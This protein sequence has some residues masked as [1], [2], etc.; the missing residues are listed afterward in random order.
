MTRPTTKKHPAGFRYIEQLQGER[1]W[2]AVLDAGTGASSMRWI[3]SLTTQRWTAVTGSQVHAGRVRQMLKTPL[4]AKDRLIVGNWADPQFCKGEAY[5]TVL[6]DYLLGALEGFSPYFQPYLFK[7]L[8][9]L[10]RKTL[11]V[12]GLEPYVPS[13]KPHTKA[14]QVLWEIGRFRDACVLMAGGLPYREYPLAWVADHLQS[15][16]F[17]VQNTKHFKIGYK[18]Q[19]VNAQIDIA[20]N[21]LKA[22]ADRDLAHSLG[23]RGEAL[24]TQALD[25]IKAE[26]ALR[27]CQNYVIAATPA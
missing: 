8:Y 24:R 12:K 9:P 17:V 3:Q 20:T 16:G 22:M 15:A 21:G 5:D 25:L 26:G 6:A 2:G 18:E 19:F 13:P 23:R 27:S 10:T 7:R 11:Y 1:P 4:R 14:G